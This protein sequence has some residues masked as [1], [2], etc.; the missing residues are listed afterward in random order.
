[1]QHALRCIFLL[2]HVLYQERD[3]RS[4]SSDYD[5]DQNDKTDNSDDGDSGE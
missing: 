5:N 3:K 4:G 2:R 1:M